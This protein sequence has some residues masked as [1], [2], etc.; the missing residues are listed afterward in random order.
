MDGGD[1]RGPAPEADAR[2]ARTC[3]Q[4]LGSAP[5]S[6]FAGGSAPAF[7]ASRG[8]V[9][10]SV[11]E[12]LIGSS[13]AT[14]RVQ[15]SAPLLES[16][17]SANASFEVRSP[18]RLQVKFDEAGVET[19]TIVNDVFQYMSLPMTVDVMGQSIDLSLIHI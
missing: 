5:S 4:L 17:V 1:F 18:K 15:L 11:P 19:P 16:S 9:F 6:S 7:V 3:S 13:H 8:V 10:P 12:R 14:L 2:D